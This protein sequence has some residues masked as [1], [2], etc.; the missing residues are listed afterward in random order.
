MKNN[1][2]FQNK[3]AQ[4]KGT[5]LDFCKSFNSLQPFFF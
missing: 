5:D 1:S 3:F 4:K 2:I